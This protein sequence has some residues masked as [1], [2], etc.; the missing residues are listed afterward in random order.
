MFG[1]IIDRDEMFAISAWS[2]RFGSRK[3]LLDN[4]RFY[5]IRY[6]ALAWLTF[7]FFLLSFSFTCFIQFII[8]V[9]IKPTKPL[10][11]LSYAIDTSNC[12][13]DRTAP[14]WF[15]FLL[16]SL[17]FVLHFCLLSFSFL[18]SLLSSSTFILIFVRARMPV[19]VSVCWSD[20]WLALSFR[21]RLLLYTLYR[22]VFYLFWPNYSLSCHSIIHW[23]WY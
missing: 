3:R 7:L 2:P 20:W 15:M 6:S 5:S 16:S 11:L 17:A 14:I 18:F 1:I 22:N 13:V 8:L 23:I 9:D 21:V 4:I 19:C 12:F 10:I